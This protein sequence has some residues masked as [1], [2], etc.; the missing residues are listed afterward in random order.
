MKAPHPFPPSSAPLPFNAPL[1][2]ENLPLSA[3]F[4]SIA[5]LLP[6]P[7]VFILYGVDGMILPAIVLGGHS[8]LAFASAAIAGL[9]LGL[10]ARE[11]E[12]PRRG[13]LSLGLLLNLVCTVA[14]FFFM[15]R[16]HEAPEERAIPRSS[17]LRT[18]HIE[19]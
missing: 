6:V 19:P 5:A 11:R 18:A 1:P 12:D 2:P 16:L 4:F 8:C 7:L 9:F 13:L 17:I 3:S 10:T 14:A 15:F